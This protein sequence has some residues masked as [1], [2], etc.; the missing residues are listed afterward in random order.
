MN[1]EGTYLYL[2]YMSRERKRNAWPRENV[3][4]L[5]S[6]CYAGEPQHGN[7]HA[8]ESPHPKQ[9]CGQTPTQFL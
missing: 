3:G 7:A 4:K 5:I 9:R 1:S 2:V 8:V 6:R